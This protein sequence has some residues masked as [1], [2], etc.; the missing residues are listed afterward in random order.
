MANLSDLTPEE[1][2]MLSQMGLLR[3]VSSGDTQGAATENGP[4]AARALSYSMGPNAGMATGNVGGSVPFD[5]GSLRGGVGFT[6]TSG[7][8]GNATT[9]IPNIGASLGPA[10]ANYAAIMAPS[11]TMHGIGGGYDFGPFAMNYQRTVPEGQGKASNTVGV[12]VPMGRASLNAS[13]TWGH[14]VPTQFSGGVRVPGLLDGDLDVTA[15]YS[16]DDKRKAIFG[17]YSKRF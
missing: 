4:I 12:S 8:Q 14:G 3:G 6:S 10:S 5:G 2:L 11:G 7:P 17:R 15:S 1:M 9:A 16:P 13:G